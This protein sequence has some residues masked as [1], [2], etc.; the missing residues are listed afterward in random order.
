MYNPRAGYIHHD[1][2]TL[3]SKRSAVT[4]DPRCP[5]V[6][7]A[8]QSVRC[9]DLERA[10]QLPVQ[11]RPKSEVPA[12]YGAG[13]RRSRAKCVRKIDPASKASG[14]CRVLRAV[15][16]A[17]RAPKTEVLC[18]PGFSQVHVGVLRLLIHGCSTQPLDGRCIIVA[19]EC[20][21][22]WSTQGPL[23]RLPCWARSAQARPGLCLHPLGPL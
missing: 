4:S 7:R 13:A 3:H 15:T 2:F 8:L 20:A 21:P 11:A 6:T 19:G 10:G 17:C 22:A 14:V 16:A 1:S 12:S 9:S 5:H 23:L 18:I